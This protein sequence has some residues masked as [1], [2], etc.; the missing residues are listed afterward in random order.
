MRQ[1]SVL[2]LL[3]ALST[4]ACGGA[5]RQGLGALDEGRYPDAVGAFRRAERDFPNWPESRRIHYALYRSLSHLAVGDAR[6]TAR[7][8]GYAKT[9]YDRHPELL[10]DDDRGRLLAA[11]R[12]IGRMPGEPPSSV[13]K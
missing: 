13:S 4:F 10:A 1:N 3:L 8:L 7:W 9:A 12:T 5:Y 2:C 11:W 6:E